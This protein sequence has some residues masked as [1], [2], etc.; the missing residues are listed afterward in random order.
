VVDRDEALQY[1]LMSSAQPA[2]PA[3]GVGRARVW[4][5]PCISPRYQ[6][7]EPFAAGPE[8]NATL[9]CEDAMVAV[10]RIANAPAAPAR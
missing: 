2:M 1:F 10:N 6:A 8:D 4:I 9:V 3:S 7:G 5:M